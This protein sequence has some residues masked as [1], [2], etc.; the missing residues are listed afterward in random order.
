[1]VETNFYK[2]SVKQIILFILGFKS[3]PKIYNKIENEVKKG[4]EIIKQYFKGK[5][6]YSSFTDYNFHLNSQK[7]IQNIYRKLIIKTN[8]PKNFLKIFIRTY[9]KTTYDDFTLIFTDFYLLCRM[10]INFDDSKPEKVARSPKK[11]P[12]IGENNYITPKNIILFAGDSHSFN[13]SKFLENMFDVKPIYDYDYDTDKGPLFLSQWISLSNNLMK[14][15]EG[16][17]K[18]KTIDKL[19]EDYF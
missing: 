7:I 8:F 4:V 16:I 12:I 18:P 1:M 9:S 2:F 15:K 6:Y 14:T 10:F 11:C 17:D 3:Y 13:V 19:F 5:L